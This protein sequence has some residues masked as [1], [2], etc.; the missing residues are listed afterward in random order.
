MSSNCKVINLPLLLR[1]GSV[2]CYLLKTNDTGYILIDTGSSNKRKKLE[3]TLES[4]GCKPGNL[5]LIIITHGDFDHTGN[6]SY[7]SKKYGVK[8]AM[9]QKDSTI[10]EQGNMFSNRKTGNIISRKLIGALT[11]ILFRFGKS[12]RFTPDLYLDD[13]YDLSGYGLEAK[14]VYIPGHS[15]GS[16]G[17]LTV[18]GDLY[19]GD[20]LINEDKSDKPSLNTIVD[21][22]VAMDESVKKLNGLEIDTVYPGHG[23]PFSWVKFLHL[24]S[25]SN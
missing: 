8:I 17:I 21:D 11:P 23:K 1:L 15:N 12:E 2:N 22:K 20:L 10:V 9:H 6:A 25:L 13:S 24:Y 19:C 4:E 7:L 18:S 5:R 16:I 3:E 14:V